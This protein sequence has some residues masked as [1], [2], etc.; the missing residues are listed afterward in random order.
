MIGA[1]IPDDIKSRWTL[2]VGGSDEKLNEIFQKYSEIDIFLHDSLHTYQNM[3]Y[4]FQKSWPQIKS[5]G[6][7]LSDDILGNNAFYDFSKHVDKNP[8]L[9]YQKI[10][11]ISL[12]GIVLK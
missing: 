7:L 6:Y 1:A 5:G 10:E 8:F 4:E 12:M 11:P 2:C 3:M 9:L